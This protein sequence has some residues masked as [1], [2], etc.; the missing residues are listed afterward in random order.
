L[1]HRGRGEPTEDRRIAAGT[2][3]EVN[4]PMGSSNL[5]TLSLQLRDYFFLDHS[6]HPEDEKRWRRIECAGIRLAETIGYLFADYPDETRLWA[7]RRIRRAARECLRLI[8]ELRYADEW[9]M[10]SA[11][12]FEAFATHVIEDLNANPRGPTAH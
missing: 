2:E 10:E 12:V 7:A 6:P 8:P 4:R 5:S 1:F 11:A 3:L 9:T